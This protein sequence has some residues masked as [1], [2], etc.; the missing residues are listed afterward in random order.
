MFDPL[1][2]MS[3]PYLYVKF[4]Y[5]PIQNALLSHKY[6]WGDSTVARLMCISSDFLYTYDIIRYDEWFAFCTGKQAQH[7]VT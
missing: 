3:F 6:S 4:G 1:H 7:S 2:L 5:P